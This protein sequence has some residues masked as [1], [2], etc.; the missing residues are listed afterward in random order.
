MIEARHVEAV[1]LAAVVPPTQAHRV[2][3]P[4]VALEG[5]DLGGIRRTALQHQAAPGPDRQPV[6][7]GGV[8]GAA[9]AL[10]PDVQRDRTGDRR[11]EQSA[12]GTGRRPTR[13]P[14]PRSAGRPD[15]RAT[16]ARADGRRR[17]AGRGD[18]LV[19]GAG[20]DR[21]R[22]ALQ[23]VLGLGEL[24][25][26][27]LVAPAAVQVEDLGDRPRRPRARSRHRPALEVADERHAG[28]L[29]PPRCGARTWRAS[30]GSTPRAGRPRTARCRSGTAPAARR[31]EVFG[32][33]RCG[34]REWNQSVC[35][36]DT[37]TAAH[38]ISSTTSARMQPTSSIG[39][40]SWCTTGHDLEAAVVDGGVVDGDHARHVR[41]DEQVR[42]GVL[43]RGVARTAGQLVVDL[44]LVEHRRLA[45]QRRRASSSSAPVVS[46]RRKPSWNGTMFSL[47]HSF[48]PSSVSS[49][50]CSQPS[51]SSGQAATSSTQPR[52]SATPSS[53]RVWVSSQPV[54]GE[55]VDGLGSRPVEHRRSQYSSHVIRCYAPLERG[56]PA[57][58]GDPRHPGRPGTRGGVRDQRPES[59]IEPSSD[60]PS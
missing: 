60:A 58:D 49:R 37:S 39:S 14:G 2:G 6:E 1:H 22:C 10:R 12:P 51:P 20:V 26:V 35:P 21:E 33:L 7:V 50:W 53:S 13:G 31:G 3:E 11:A 36:A 32:P 30:R 16:A 44:L 41:V 24:L 38:S 46:S 52:S 42:R 28:V 4:G 59:F 5:G 48:G 57:S 19:V 29:D 15:R 25:V 54:S 45:E 18:Q 56:S 27:A 47:R 55:V 40:T 17:A 34:V 9:V 8:D 23:G 43:V